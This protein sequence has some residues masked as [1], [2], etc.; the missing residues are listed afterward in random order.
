MKI[1]VIAPVYNTSRYLRKFIE[2]ILAQDF[3][4]YELILVDDGS[5]DDSGK[6]CDEYAEGDNRVKVIH[7]PNGGVDTA[8]NMGMEKA[9]GMY[10]YLAD[11]DDAL[12][13]GCLTALVEGMEREAD[14][15]LSVC[16]YIHSS[17]GVD[18][19]IPEGPF[20]THVF[21]R[22]RMMEELLNPVYYNIGMPWTNLFRASVI[23]KNN[24]QYNQ[25]IHTI[26]DRLFLAS[27]INAMKGKAV[28][29]TRPIYVYNLGV[30][31]SFQ[32]KG[33]YDK[34]NAT[35]FKGQCMIYDI[36][37]NGGF[38]AKNI[39]WARFR[40]MNSYYHKSRYFKSYNDHATADELKEQLFQ[41]V[42]RKDYFMFTLRKKCTEM[43]SP[44]VPFL[45]KIRN[46]LRKRC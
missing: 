19:A 39:W 25:A 27:Y 35:I 21:N 10:Y 1:S 45:R 17:N 3:T 7:K 20:E 36:V 29:S 38:S 2:S 4:D 6:I 15:D 12:L 22:D 34:R 33:K 14:V 30:G 37:K 16:G 42:T 24:L 43:L 41:K 18:E 46:R 32:V 5:T 8:R 26:D 23:K 9:Q 31:V 11:S 40:M 28:H 44:L 13:P